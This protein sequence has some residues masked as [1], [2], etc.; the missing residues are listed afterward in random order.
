MKNITRYCVPFTQVEEF[1]GFIEPCGQRINIGSEEWLGRYTMVGVAGRHVDV[2]L[3]ERIRTVD[4][5]PDADLVVEWRADKAGKYDGTLRERLAFRLISHGLGSYTPPLIPSHLRI[6]RESGRLRIEIAK[7]DGHLLAAAS[8]PMLRYDA[9]PDQLERIAGW[10]LSRYYT[11]LLD[12]PDI[13]ADIHQWAIGE[14]AQMYAAGASV[15]ALNRAADR[16]LYQFSREAG[17]RKMTLRERLGIGFDRDSPQWQRLSDI[18]ARYVARG[19]ASRV[20]TEASEM[21]RPEQWIEAWE[22]V[23]ERLA[24]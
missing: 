11:H 13:T 24:A 10:K 16:M 4:A 2:L 6:I 20:Q 7:D 3:D 22:E 15:A 21:G 1:L 5:S 19:Y 23:E 8:W 12:N 18:D 9:R 14:G 17:W